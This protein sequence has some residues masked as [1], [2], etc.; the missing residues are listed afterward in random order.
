M[1]VKAQEISPHIVRNPPQ[2]VQ[3][4]QQLKLQDL[5]LRLLDFLNIPE[6]VSRCNLWRIKIYG[7]ENV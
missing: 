3:G 5:L 2:E 6:V 1:V 7:K 4:D